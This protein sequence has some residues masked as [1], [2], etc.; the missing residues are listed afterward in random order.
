MQILFNLVRTG[1]ETPMFENTTAVDDKSIMKLT[2]PREAT[3]VEIFDSIKDVPKFWE[4][5]APPNNIFLQRQYLTAL[6]ACPPY[7]M[8]LSYLLFY[9]NSQPI[10]LAL[11]QIQYFRAE[12]SIAKEENKKS[13]CFFNAIAN[14][15]KG[16]VARKVEFNTLICGNLLLTGAHGI[17]FDTNKIE[18]KK[19]FK[20]VIHAIDHLIKHWEKKGKPISVTLIKDYTQDQLPDTRAFTEKAFN[21]FSIQP[22]MYLGIR[23]EWKSFDDYMASLH[24]KYRVRVRRAF[25]KIKGLERVEFS[26]SDIERNLGEMYALYKQVAK[27]A[28]F[29]AVNLHEGYLLELKR[30]LQDN[31]RLFAYYLED[32]LVAYYT[33]IYN[34]RELEAHFLG[35]DNEINRS[36]QVYLNILLEILRHG[37]ETGAEKI[38]YART[39]LEIKS[40][41][42]AVAEEMACYLRHKRSLPNRFAGQIFDYLKPKSDWVPRHPFKS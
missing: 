29:N 32:R 6:E 10:G 22:N 23:P 34:G 5:V 4:Q 15:F 40:S 38:I 36:H 28:G 27:N 39:A 13:P 30:Q 16:L 7:G 37:I 20:L 24:S 1:N 26:E 31:F 14:Y 18:I 25:K 17:Y 3:S 41:V 35:I 19:G 42:G 33:I 2:L 12:D 11:A 8:N 21:E 9:Q